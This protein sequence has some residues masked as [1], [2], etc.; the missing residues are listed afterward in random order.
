MKGTLRRK[1]ASHF[2]TGKGRLPSQ[3]GK[4]SLGR[5]R[6]G[7][8]LNKGKAVDV[9]ERSAR[10]SGE[11]RGRPSIHL[12]KD[13]RAGGR[14]WTRFSRVRYHIDVKVK[15]G[16]ARVQVCSMLIEPKKN[17]ARILRPGKTDKVV[18][19]KKG[20]TKQLRVDANLARYHERWPNGRHFIS[21]VVV[22]PQVKRAR[23]SY[24]LSV[25]A[26]RSEVSAKSHSSAK[27]GLD[28]KSV[29][30]KKTKGTPGGKDHAKANAGPPTDR[31]LAHIASAAYGDPIAVSN[32]GCK[33]PTDCMPVDYRH[34]VHSQTAKTW[35]KDKFQAT[36]VLNQKAKSMV[37][38]YRGTYSTGSLHTDIGLFAAT[39][40]LY[41]TGSLKACISAASKKCSNGGLCLRD[42]VVR[43]PSCSGLADTTFSLSKL[44]AILVQADVFFQEARKKAPSGTKIYLTGHSLGGYIATYIAS[45]YPKLVKKTVVFNAPPGARYALLTRRQNAR[46]RDGQLRDQ[47]GETI[48]NFRIATDIVSAFAFM[49]SSVPYGHTG[50][51]CRFKGVGGRTLSNKDLVKTFGQLTTTGAAMFT[52]VATLSSKFQSLLKLGK[53]YYDSHKMPMILKRFRDGDSPKCSTAPRHIYFW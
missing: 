50:K 16:A 19:F 46:A 22:Q 5:V 38:A 48:T 17:R 9:S 42:W 52:N 26:K 13:S 44:A 49:K 30:P 2:A 1:A 53:F 29:G 24:Q 7:G 12:L 8:G 28:K 25:S 31:V 11:L 15:S 41:Y 21:F 37:I 35:W 51:I 34:R 45:K 47:K 36:A 32:P 39:V 3:L 27:T 43:G 6:P 33:P 14:S 20:Q 23:V 40:G 4:S 18:T 10:V